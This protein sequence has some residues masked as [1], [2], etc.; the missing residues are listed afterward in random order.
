[1]NVFK[2]FFFAGLAVV[3][4]ACSPVFAGVSATAPACC[5]KGSCCVAG[6]CC[7]MKGCCK[8]DKSCCDPAKGTCTS[9]C[10]CAA[11]KC[12]GGEK[13][14]AVKRTRQAVSKVKRGSKTPSAPAKTVARTARK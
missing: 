10:G 1:M 4:I 2:N 6:P 13:A 5:A 11:M 3:A 9:A 8:P 7:T 14:A 12:C